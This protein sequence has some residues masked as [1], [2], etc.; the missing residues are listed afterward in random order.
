[1]KQIGEL[2]DCKKALNGLK[3]FWN[4]VLPYDFD[5]DGDQDYIISFDD[6]PKIFQNENG[7]YNFYQELDLNLNVPHYNRAWCKYFGENGKTD[8]KCV[9]I[10]NL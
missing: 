1:M 2:Q 9:L 4:F 10:K 3:G 8:N 6:G 7:S 5:G